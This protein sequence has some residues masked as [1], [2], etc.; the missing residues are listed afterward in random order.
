MVDL[1]FAY[2][3][4]GARRKAE[5]ATSI[6][7]RMAPHDLRAGFNLVTFR[8]AIRDYEGAFKELDRLQ[9]VMPN[10]LRVS[11]AKAS[12][13]QLE[14]DL[15]RARREL[16]IVMASQRFWNAEPLQ[17]E[18]LRAL[19]SMIEFDSGRLS[20][21]NLISRLEK[22]IDRTEARSMLI[23]QGLANV[24][25]TGSRNAS[26][27]RSLI[28]R[29]ATIHP[30]EALYAPKVRLA[31]AEHDYISA[32]DL[33]RRWLEYEPFNVWA[34]AQSTYVMIS[35]ARYEDAAKLGTSFLT[36][37]DDRG[38]VL[39][40]TAYAYAMLGDS[41]RARDLLKKAEKDS[42]QIVATR[43][44]IDLLGGNIDEGR[45]GY[46]AAAKMAEKEGQSDLA[47]LVRIKLEKVLTSLGLAPP[48]KIAVPE[49]LL[50]DPRFELIELEAT[51]Q[52]QSLV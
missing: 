49:E 30:Q 7:V 20:R 13:Y 9:E 8:T 12:L 11:M 2:A 18:D 21:D 51:L 26:K 34:G 46:L 45:G 33:S 5:R 10:D 52:E 50:D 17:K 29:M 27:L 25:S 43:A 15:N 35:L 48:E 4:I 40:N 41:V 42:P 44:L 6:A 28:E 23:A 24:Y 32:V 22:A 14:G 1:G 47:V 16:Q 38:M 36:R 3:S 31:V 19:E 37:V 39:N